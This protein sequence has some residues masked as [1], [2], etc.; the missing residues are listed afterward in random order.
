MSLCFHV[1]LGYKLHEA[2]RFLPPP[3]HP[4]IENG[5]LSDTHSFPSM[6]FKS[7]VRPLTTRMAAE[8]CVCVHGSTC[9]SST[10][11]HPPRSC[12][13]GHSLIPRPPQASIAWGSLGRPGYKAMFIVCICASTHHHP[14]R[15]CAVGH[16]LIPRLLS[17]GEAWVRGYVHYMCIHSPSPSQVLCCRT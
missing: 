15:S 10:H 12:A 14:P 13:V 16:S 11:H 2:S 5:W 7:A 9:M 8:L 4:P 1:I 6:S 17:L 3:P